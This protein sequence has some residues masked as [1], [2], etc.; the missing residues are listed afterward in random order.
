MLP[1]VTFLGE[2]RFAYE[3]YR[4]R[5]LCFERY[6]RTLT[7]SILA[8]AYPRAMAYLS[9]LQYVDTPVD[10]SRCNLHIELATARRLVRV[11][12]AK[13]Q[14]FVEHGP[15]WRHTTSWTLPWQHLSSFLSISSSL[16]SYMPRRPAPQPVRVICQS[17]SF[18][19][20]QQLSTRDRILIY[21]RIAA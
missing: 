9:A 14:W 1:L 10:G 15:R 16:P 6:V 13:Q 3:T 5:F 17:R 4:T 7:Y 21:Y 19:V 12:I 2:F 11:S 18:S 20:R 8:Y